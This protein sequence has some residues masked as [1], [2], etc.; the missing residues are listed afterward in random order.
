MNYKVGPL[1]FLAIAVPVP[2][3]TPSEI[4]LRHLLRE[5]E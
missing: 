4:V 5:P 2:D 3:S 1:L